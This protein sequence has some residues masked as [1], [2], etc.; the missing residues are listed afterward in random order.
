MATVA[1]IEHA[2][3][4]RNEALLAGDLDRLATLISDDLVHIHGSGK[5][6]TKTSYLA[7]VGA[8][9]FQRIDPTDIRIRGAGDVFVV[10]SALEQ[11]V[12]VKGKDAAT[13]MNGF[14][15]RVWRIEDGAPKLW[16]FQMTVVARASAG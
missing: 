5:I 12:L 4:A 6:D 1:D 9:A 16:S 11:Q 3:R 8:L 7:S 15:T 2:E 14:A 10:T 13:T